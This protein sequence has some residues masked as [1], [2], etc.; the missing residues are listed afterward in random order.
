MNAL[1]HEEAGVNELLRSLAHEPSTADELWPLLKP[2]THGADA[3][4]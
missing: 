1:T 4:A 2:S 3:A